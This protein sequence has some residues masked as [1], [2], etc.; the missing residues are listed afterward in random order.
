MRELAV[1]TIISKNYL[2]YARVLI[3]S[4]LRHNKGEAFVLLVDRVDGCFDPSAE[5]FTLIEIEDLGEH[6]PEFKRFCFQYTLLELNTAVK[7]YFMEYLFKKYGLEKLAYFDP[8]ILITGNLNELSGLLDSNDVVLTPHLTAP[9][10]DDLKPGD[11]EILQTG[12][13][14]LGF[15]GLSAGQVS[16]KLLSWW[17]RR[18][19]DNCIVAFEKGLFVDQRWIDLVPGFFDSVHILREPGYNV[20][21][22]N[23]HCRSVS[24]EG[25][26]FFVNGKP[27][28]FF[29]FS[30][31]DP[32]NPEPVSKYQN[33]YTIDSLP[34]MK[35]LFSLYSGLVQERGW[36]FTKKWPYAF[37]KFD[38]GVRIP[39][40]ARRLYLDMGKKGEQFGNPF[41]AGHDGSYYNWLNSPARKTEPSISRLL[42][43]I[44]LAR[45]D[46]RKAFPDIF[47][48]DNGS[49][50]AWVLSTCRKEYGL[51]EEFLAA[52]AE[53][54]KGLKFKTNLYSNMYLRGTADYAY[55][56]LL[57]VFQRN[58]T[59]WTI[60]KKVNDSLPSSASIKPPSDMIRSVDVNEL[61]AG[62]FGS[63]IA[64]YISAES[65]TGEAARAN[66]RSA[67]CAGIPIALNNIESNSRQ[68]DRTYSAFTKE[69]PYPINLIHVNAD[70]VTNFFRKNGADYFRNKY[71]I[72]FWYWEL[73]VF[74]EEWL[75]RF[76]LFN[77]IWVA[78]SFCQEAVSRVS[79]IPVIKIPP[80][81]V[82]DDTKKINRKRFGLKDGEFLFLFIFDFLSFPERKNPLALIE[83]FKKAFR[84]GEN[85]RLVIK[86]TNSEKN[87]S[88]RQQLIDS[89]KG[90]NVSFIDEYL[91]KDDVHSLMAECDCYVSLHRSEGFGLTIAEA[92]YLRKPVIATAYSS[93][94]DFMNVNNSF[95]VKYRLVEIEKDIGPYKKGNL[96][97]EPDVTH[98]AELMRFVYDNKESSAE[99]G[100]NASSDIKKNLSPAVC[101]GL[102][103]DRFKRITQKAEFSS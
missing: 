69:N 26:K 49:F 87:P 76:A 8:D 3:D 99:C 55:K 10:E 7:P 12:A 70:Q 59:V 85:A 37:A 81:V 36:A 96:W 24:S 97:A 29:H 33:R 65:G 45:I 77:E 60:L 80:S 21:Y 89:A 61:S 30:G 2:P 38:N 94:M 90:L 86:S 23:Y 75:D 103:L 42:Y 50:L 11:L 40:F 13:Y 43:S 32:E 1:C 58:R 91:D 101:G 31:F 57:P 53:A 44:Y 51:D 95:P 28:C 25:D 102:I 16:E 47:G 64:G 15:I 18:L 41:S 88:L 71:N 20:A 22:W 9:I 62:T 68:G 78:S 73:S 6:I 79:P 46:I 54:G 4:F 35:S 100:R 34:G 92:M 19:H 39:S 66:I 74:P 48:K 84:P 72:G 14:N 5:N 56:T 93:N 27:S 82:I 63:N 17:Q 52:A 98:A 83:S 67:Q